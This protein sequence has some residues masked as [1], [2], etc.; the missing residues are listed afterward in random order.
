MVRL[1]CAGVVYVIA[2][3]R[4]H[5]LDVGKRGRRL[6]DRFSEHL[7]SVEG[8]HQNPRYQAGGFPV[9]EHFNFSDQNKIHDIRVSVVR[10]LQGGTTV[11][12]REEMQL[13]FQLGPLASAP[14]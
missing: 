14:V 12:Q 5:M 6:V 9:G 10:Q 1:H 8:Y 13:I 2:Y 4:C 11:R 3:Q 7:S